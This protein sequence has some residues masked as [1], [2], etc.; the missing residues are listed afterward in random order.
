MKRS[1]FMIALMA[2]FAALF[3]LTSCEKN[4][5]PAG[6][7]TLVVEV[8]SPK[9]DSEV[10]IF[11]YGMSDQAYPIA[12]ESFKKGASKTFTFVLNAGDY[13][14]ECGGAVSIDGRSSVTV[15]I[16]VGQEHKVKFVGN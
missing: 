1:T 10:E 12:G 14:V 15:Q 7:G 6:T 9:Y 2:L 8:S 13:V 5:L 11:P 3:M 16:Q 4:E